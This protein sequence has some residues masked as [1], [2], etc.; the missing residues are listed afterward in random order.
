VQ[1]QR[2]KREDNSFIEKLAIV[3]VALF[4]IIVLLLL[5]GCM[6]EDYLAQRIGLFLLFVEMVLFF[7]LVAITGKPLAKDEDEKEKGYASEA[8]RKE[9]KCSDWTW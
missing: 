3:V 4:M 1:N 7:T 8:I 6:Q 9:S 2:K 5:Y